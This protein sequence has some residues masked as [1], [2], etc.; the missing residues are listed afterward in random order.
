MFQGGGDFG[1]GAAIAVVLMGMILPLMLW[2]MRQIW[3]AEGQGR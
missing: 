2:V 1:R 3:R